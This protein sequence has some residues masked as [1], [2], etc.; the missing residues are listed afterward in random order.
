MVCG[1]RNVQAQRKLR[2]P[3]FAHLRHRVRGTLGDDE[4]VAGAIHEFIMDDLT[5]T[6]TEIWEID[7]L[8]SRIWFDVVNEGGDDVTD[9]RLMWAVDWDQDMSD[10]SVSTTYSTIN[11]VNDDGDFE[12]IDGGMMAIS[13]GPS[14]GR[15]VIL[16]S[17]NG[18]AQSLG[19]TSPWSR[20]IDD[21]MAGM[22]DYDGSSVDA[23]A[24][25]IASGLEIP[26]GDTLSFGLLVVV[27]E[28]A[29]EAVEA[30][31]EQA[32]ILCTE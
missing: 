19:Y 2:L 7:G 1:Q 20:D 31:A 14:S 30:Y 4:T 13:E 21:A 5:V 28:D 25:W 15:T 3:I 24:H 11:D 16:G 29:D 8:V 10:S 18:D 12:G 9:F 6:K 26:V 23:A 17:C 32:P 22:V 27:G